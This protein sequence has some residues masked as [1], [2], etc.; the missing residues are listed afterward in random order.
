MKEGK[1]VRNR[2]RV[3]RISNPRRWADLPRADMLSLCG[4]LAFQRYCDEWFRCGGGGALFIG[5]NLVEGP[6]AVALTTLPQLAV[7]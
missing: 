5:A 3:Y 6:E 4:E 1:L 2:D 7:S